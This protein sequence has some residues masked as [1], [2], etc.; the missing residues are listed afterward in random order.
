MEIMQY[1]QLFDYDTW[2]YTYLIWDEDSK[3][4]ALIDPVISQVERDLTLIRDLGLKLVYTME[5]HIHADHV[6]GGGLIRAQTG[7]KFVTHK[8][9]SADCP[10][11]KVDD[12]DVLT[13][14]Q[15]T[16]EI[17]HTPGHT[18][19]DITFF[20][21]G[22]AFTGDTLF[23]RDCGRTDFQ[24]GDTRAMWH[25]I[26]EK[27]FSL[28]EETLVLPAHDYNGHT[29]STIGEEKRYNRRIAGKDF[30]TFKQIMESLELPRPRYMDVSVPNNLLCGDVDPHTIELAMNYLRQ[31][32][33]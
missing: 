2:S 5:T 19:N 18:N 9:V 6:T 27:L 14:G 13:L 30:E 7:A 22:K 24:L 29:M 20:T 31:Q 4:A 33:T 11:L 23:V 28:P 25:S 3:Q 1:R 32:N 17:L 26:T 12:G 8:N 16:I 15:Q 10:D 21:D